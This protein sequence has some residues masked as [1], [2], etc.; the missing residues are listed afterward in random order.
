M[1]ENGNVANKGRLC[2]VCSTEAKDLARPLPF[3]HVAHSRLICAHTGEPLNENNPPLCL[4]NGMVYGQNAIL[5]LAG[6]SGTGHIVCPRTKQIFALSDA[7][8]VYVM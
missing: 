2:P 8:K 4:P 3:A 7:E 1:I 5:A 6:E